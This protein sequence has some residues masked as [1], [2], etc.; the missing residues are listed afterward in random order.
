MS[1]LK[2][3]PGHQKCKKGADIMYNYANNCQAWTA[4]ASAL[5]IYTNYYQYYT[6]LSGATINNSVLDQHQYQVVNWQQLACYQTAGSMW[7]SQWQV[8]GTVS[9]TPEQIAERA[10]REAAAKAEAEVAASRADIL[11]MSFLS[12]SQADQYKRDSRFDLVINGRTYR[13]NKGR[14]GN[15]Q[16]IENGKP[17]AKYCAH[18]EIWTPDGDT[19][20]AQMLMLKTDEA[21]FLQVANRTAL[22]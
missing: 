8:I 15:I 21:R 4:T 20:L 1:P 16:L 12:D 18:P 10:K 2:K 22:V 3:T 11:L 13:I 7:A 14:S 6:T 9:A 5:D 19:M 17:V